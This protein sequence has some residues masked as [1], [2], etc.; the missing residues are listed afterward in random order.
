MGAS[1]FL[2]LVA[3]SLPLGIV[4]ISRD[5]TQ[6][7]A[8]AL[9]TSLFPI[10]QGLGVRGV[11]VGGSYSEIRLLRRWLIQG[12]LRVG[13]GGGMGLDA[14]G[15]GALGQGGLIGVKIRRRGEGFAAAGYN[16]GLGPVYFHH[17]ADT[18]SHGW[19]SL[20]RRMV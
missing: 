5:K 11:W 17:G 2:P 20:G 12:V 19:H 18:S 8:S 9:L 4:Y 7:V 14:L 13:G 10:L 16:D 3:G 15:L 6:R 1:T